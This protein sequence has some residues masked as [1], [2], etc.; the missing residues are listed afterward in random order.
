MSLSRK[1]APTK[2]KAT[3]P[4][5]SAVSQIVPATISQVPRDNGTTHL[6]APPQTPADIPEELVA[7]RAYELWQQR[8]CP[9]GQDGAEDW[10][11]AREQLEQ[12]RLNWA[13]PD[14]SDKQRGV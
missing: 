2:P 3:Q 4:V 11:A 13:A 7:A 6:A 5:T 12:E 10:Y 8:G 1:R 14:A 9:T